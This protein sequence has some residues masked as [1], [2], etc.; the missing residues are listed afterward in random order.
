MYLNDLG[1]AITRRFNYKINYLTGDGNIIFYR[2]M[3]IDLIDVPIDIVNLNALKKI[4]GLT[5]GN[6]KTVRDR[7]SFCE[8]GKISNR[9]LL[10]NA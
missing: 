6:F 2:K 8:K 1:Q 9:I 10:E 7:F 5:P 3:L 4:H